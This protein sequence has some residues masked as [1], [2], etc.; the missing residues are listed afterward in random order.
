[1]DIV[2]DSVHYTNLGNPILIFADFEQWNMIVVKI[3]ATPMAASAT[4][5]LIFPPI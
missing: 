3:P 2:V 1:M 4:A 5:C